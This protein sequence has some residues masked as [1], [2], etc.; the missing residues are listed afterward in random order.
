MRIAFRSHSHHMQQECNGNAMGMWSTFPLRTFLQSK[1]WAHI[2]S[3]QKDIYHHTQREAHGGS[4]ACGVPEKIV[5]AIAAIYARTWAKN[6]NAWQ[7]I[8]VLLNSLRS[9]PR[10][11]I[12][13]LPFYAP[14]TCF[15]PLLTWPWLCW[16][17]FSSLAFNTIEQTCKLLAIKWHYKRIGLGLI[18][19]KKTEVKAEN[20]DLPVVTTLDGTQLEVVKDFQYPWFWIV[21][22][23]YDNEI[24]R[25]R[26][27]QEP[28]PLSSVHS[29]GWKAWA[30][31]V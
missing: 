28:L 16:R 12:P 26:A 31:S 6:I 20:V 1:L 11:H 4:G 29:Y 24:R 17:N 30:L 3:F 22:T 23:K 9:A 14:Q 25:A 27:W 15:R 7:W 8:W 2:Y 5:T 18:N 19:A 13:T 10:W 21:T